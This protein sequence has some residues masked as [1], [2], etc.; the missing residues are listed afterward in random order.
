MSGEVRSPTAGSSSAK[1]ERCERSV[2][3]PPSRGG[4]RTPLTFEDYILGYGTDVD[5]N[6]LET[7]ASPYQRSEYM[8]NRS[9]AYNC[10]SLITIIKPED[11]GWQMGELLFKVIMRYGYKVQ[12]T[13]SADADQ[14]NYL[15]LCI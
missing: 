10:S 13:I 9:P 14:H 5:L 7:L 3:V 1:A 8:L 2:A 6:C 11:I 12:V 15:Y 4:T